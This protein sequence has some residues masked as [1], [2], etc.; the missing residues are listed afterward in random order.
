MINH[1]ICML[2]INQ[3]VSRKSDKTNIGRHPRGILPEE[4]DID[5]ASLR[6]AIDEFQS[7][8]QRAIQHAISTQL[9]ENIEIDLLPREET[10]VVNSFLLNLR[11]IAYVLSEKVQLLS[12]VYRETASDMLKH[13]RDL[14]AERRKYKTNHRL[15]FPEIKRGKW[16]Q[17]GGDEE[18]N[19][20]GQRFK[21]VADYYQASDKKKMD[22][23]I[24]EVHEAT[25]QQS[26]DQIGYDSSRFARLRET[27]AN[28]IDWF[29]YSDDIHYAFK[30]T[31][32]LLLV[33]FPSFIE[34][35]A[36][37]FYISRAG[38][39]STSCYSDLFTY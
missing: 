38:K 3:D 35:T 36:Q 12:N 14:V 16:L 7:S 30:L 17:T 10:F 11:L 39:P 20:F 37:W 4:L 33:T 13:G 9:A 25:Q 15:H 26:V 5:I 31:V 29:M 19:R 18:G 23:D 24:S 34:T 2:I 32:G 27:A 21:N 1:T 6:D 28:V 22:T 8:S